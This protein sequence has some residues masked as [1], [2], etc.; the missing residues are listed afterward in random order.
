[1]QLFEFAKRLRAEVEPVQRRRQRVARQAVDGVP[2]RLEHHAVD[3]HAFVIEMIFVF[4][5]QCYYV[6]VMTKINEQL[7]DAID[8][9]S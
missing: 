5:R 4:R 3:H 2:H 8:V 7:C 6:N 9:I 1:M